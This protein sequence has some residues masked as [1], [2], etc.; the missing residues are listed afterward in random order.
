M[1]KEISK[2]TTDNMRQHPDNYTVLLILTDGEIHDMEDTIDAIVAASTL[3]MSIIIIGV[4]NEKFANMVTLDSDDRKLRSST[5]KIAK[6]DIVQFVP[7]KK[8]QSTSYSGEGYGNFNGV[9]DALADAVLKELPRQVCN[10]YKG[11]GR[12]PNKEIKVNA[13]NFLQVRHDIGMN[14]LGGGPQTAQ[15]YPTESEI[16]TKF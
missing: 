14:L 8:Y 10:Y 6:R 16:Q 1:I 11:Q 3:A 7:L 12:K 4:G 13:D 2:F 9:N 15:N 5:G